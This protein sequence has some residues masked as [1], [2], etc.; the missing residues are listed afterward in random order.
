MEEFKVGD[1]VCIKDIDAVLGVDFSGN[2]F[3]RRG[4]IDKDFII[5]VLVNIK[6]KFGV[7]YDPEPGDFNK[8][9]IIVYDPIYDH[10]LCIINKFLYPYDDISLPDD[11]F[12]I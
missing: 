8:P 1:K 4:N 7:V 10:Y 9:Y 6:R 2:L 5:K 11:L 3:N 12:K